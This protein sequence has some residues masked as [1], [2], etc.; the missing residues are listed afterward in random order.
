VRVEGIHRSA[1]KYSEKAAPMQAQVNKQVEGVRASSSTP[2]DGG[3]PTAGEKSE[4]RDVRGEIL[5]VNT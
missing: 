2:S 5:I 1:A 3:V 4:Q